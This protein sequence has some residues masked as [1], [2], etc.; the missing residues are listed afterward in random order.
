MFN[1]LNSHTGV[2]AVYST[3]MCL[4]VRRPDLHDGPA[5]GCWDRTHRQAG[6]MRS[7]FQRSRL[8]RS[9]LWEQR[10]RGG[11]AWWHESPPAPFRRTSP[12]LH[13]VASPRL[14]LPL[15]RSPP[16]FTCDWLLS[17]IPRALA[18]RLGAADLHPD[19]IRPGWLLEHNCVDCTIVSARR[20]WGRGERQNARQEATDAH[21]VAVVH[22]QSSAGGTVRGRSCRSRARSAAGQFPAQKCKGG[23][24]CRT[25]HTRGVGRSQMRVCGVEVVRGRPS[26]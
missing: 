5:R 19:R 12:T 3:E 21:K 26:S 7:V 17:C 23:A 16:L 13:A 11:Y 9:G 6:A 20:G 14:F 4:G 8:G 25:Q 22:T 24:R 1:N 15:C 2:S 10:T 18:T